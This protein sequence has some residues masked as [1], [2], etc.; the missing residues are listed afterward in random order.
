MQW[1]AKEEE[2][3]SIDED[4]EDDDDE[5]D[6]PYD[7]LESMAKEGKQPKGLSLS[8]EGG[9]CR[10]NCC[11]VSRRT[12][13]SRELWQRAEET[14]PQG[15]KGRPALRGRRNPDPKRWQGHCHHPL[16]SARPRPR[17]PRRGPAL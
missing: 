2:S 5:W 17:Q 6:Y 10:L 11:A 8:I 9:Y 12:S 3:T 1:Q 4:D 15:R 16:S 7:W 14:S 13:T